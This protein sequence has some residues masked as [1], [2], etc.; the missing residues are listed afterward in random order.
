MLHALRKVLNK[1]TFR[2]IKETCLKSSTLKR[3]I[4]ERFYEY[5][6]D[7]FN[8]KAINMQKN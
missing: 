5:S 3:I 8:K 1:E 6:F 4:E 2:N 7:N